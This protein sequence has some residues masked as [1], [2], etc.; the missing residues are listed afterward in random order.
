MHVSGSLFVLF[1]VFHDFAIARES[2]VD[3]KAQTSLVPFVVNLSWISCGL[4]VGR[5]VAVNFSQL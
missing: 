3:N 2:K 5:G 4:V 1:R